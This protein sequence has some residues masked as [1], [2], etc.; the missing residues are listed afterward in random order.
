MSL[1]CPAR[2]SQLRIRAERE[3]RH[4]ASDRGVR[5]AGKHRGDDCGNAQEKAFA[6]K[7]DFT[8]LW[9]PPTP[10]AANAINFDIKERFFLTTVKVTSGRVRAGYSALLTT[11]PARLPVAATGRV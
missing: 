11:I 5:H 2:H 10:A 3:Y 4:R 7:N 8:I 6:S 9:A 1:R